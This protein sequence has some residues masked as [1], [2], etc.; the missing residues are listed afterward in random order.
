GRG[1]VPGNGW[2]DPPRDG[3][4]DRRGEWRCGGGDRRGRAGHPVAPERPPCQAQSPPTLIQPR[5][6][7]TRATIRGRQ[8]GRVMTVDDTR[9]LWAAN[10]MVL[11]AGVGLSVGV[12][13]GGAAFV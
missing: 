9:A 6:E 2:R 11:G 1:P 12:T 10:A 4:A 7:W 5:T 8:E 3:S 13:L